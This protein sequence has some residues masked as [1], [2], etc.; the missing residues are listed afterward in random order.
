MSASLAIF[1]AAYP[2]HLGGVENFT[3][4]LA[5][6]LA[7]RGDRVVVVTNDTEGMG[8]GLADEAG[9]EVLRLPCRPLLA[10]RLPLPRAGSE[11]RRLLACLRERPL[12][13]V[14]VN[15]RFY[16]HSLLGLRLARER[17]LTPAVLDHGSA[18]LT[19]GSP[20]LDVAVRAWE[21]AITAWGRRYQAR[22]FG[23]SEKSA[24]W[25]ATFGISASGVI[26]NA[27]DA[28]AFRAAASPRDVRAE[29]GLAS[30][31]FVVAFVG[32]LVAEKGVRALVRAA[33]DP[34]LAGT[35]VTFVLAG[36]GPL[37]DEV[38]AAEGAGLRWMGRLER[39][40]AAALL[41]QADMLCLPSRSEGFATALLEAAACGCPVL[42]CDV[43][44]ARELVPDASF[45]AILPEASADAVV[46]GVLELRARR[47]E[48]PAMGE[49]CRERVERLFSWDAT[50]EAAL[51]ACA[52][53]S[54]GTT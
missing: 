29:L 33:R 26:P 49:R 13:G 39:P 19:F 35:G 30:D 11:R 25:L 1:S 53:S 18:W 21:R 16:P 6:A 41:L 9:V 5:R 38:R 2:P 23:I 24:A 47:D 12:D 15:T 51:R 34:R 48:L 22:Y 40:D 45:G 10:G 3:E 31:A 52:V 46:R 8:A 50:A 44:G 32:R 27:I 7:A 17:G 14:L 43:G 37:A 28:P 36:D 42:A 54:E 20:A 4:G